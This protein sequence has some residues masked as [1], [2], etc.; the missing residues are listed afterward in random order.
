MGH[1]HGHRGTVETCRQRRFHG[2]SKEKREEKAEYDMSVRRVTLLFVEAGAKK[3]WSID[4]AE[5]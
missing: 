4:K 2:Q 3:E 1:I 5:Q